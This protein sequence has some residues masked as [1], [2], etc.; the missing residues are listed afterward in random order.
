ML[1]QATDFVVICYSSNRKLT[2]MYSVEKQI[3]KLEDEFEELSQKPKENI[4]KMM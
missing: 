4:K 2:Q 1:F 3:S